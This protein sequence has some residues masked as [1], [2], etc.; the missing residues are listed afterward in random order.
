MKKDNDEVLS[1][2]AARVREAP[3]FGFGRARL[4]LDSSEI[5]FSLYAKKNINLHI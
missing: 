5:L 4:V 2:T 3:R 1:G